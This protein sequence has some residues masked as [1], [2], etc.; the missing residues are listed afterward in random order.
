[1]MPSVDGAAAEANSDG[2][3]QG[4]SD[5][6]MVDM[7]VDAEESGMSE[8]QESLEITEQEHRVLEHAF[9]YGNDT[10][11]WGTHMHPAMHR[12]VGKLI[13]VGWSVRDWHRYFSRYTTRQWALFHAE[14]GGRR[15]RWSAA[16]W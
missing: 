16:E 9:P 6:Q 2:R 10:A 12:V 1:M 5:V 14:N 15:S 11:S 8:G 13:Y 4:D 3:S 7:A